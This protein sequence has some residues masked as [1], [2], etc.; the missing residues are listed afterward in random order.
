[1]T[2]CGQFEGGVCGEKNG[3]SQVLLCQASWWE[4]PE[5]IKAINGSMLEALNAKK[6]MS[7]GV[8]TLWWGH[9]VKDPSNGK[10]S[11][12]RKKDKIPSLCG[13]EQV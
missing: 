12:S 6:R 1:M 11:I 7:I 2:H 5:E 9:W 13:P 3:M 4:I 8:I 10:G